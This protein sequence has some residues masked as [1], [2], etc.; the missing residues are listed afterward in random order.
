MCLV[1]S[2]CSML[3]SRNNETYNKSIIADGTTINFREHHKIS[4]LYFFQ[5]IIKYE[6]FLRCIITNEFIF[7]GYII[8]QALSEYRLI[9][10][11]FFIAMNR[12]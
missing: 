2:V 9:L 4:T 1:K 11:I 5:I 8:S 10:Y 7:A 12:F 3:V 6:F